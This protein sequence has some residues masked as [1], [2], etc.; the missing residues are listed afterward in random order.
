MCWEIATKFHAAVPVSH[1]FLASPWVGALG[2]FVSGSATFSHLMF[3]LLLYSRLSVRV[4]EEIEDKQ[5]ES[6]GNDRKRNNTHKREKK[7]HQQADSRKR[8][9]FSSDPES[10]VDSPFLR[11]GRSH[12]HVKDYDLSPRNCQC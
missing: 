8:K 7:G 3:G 5:G 6:P 4:P 11:F 2:S 12:A 1:E 9:P 10:V